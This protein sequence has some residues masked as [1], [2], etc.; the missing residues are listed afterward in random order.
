MTH[1]KAEGQTRKTRIVQNL[2][3]QM[4]IFRVPCTITRRKI[5]NS[6][7]ID[8]CIFLLVCAIE[9]YCCQSNKDSFIIK[10]LINYNNYKN[11]DSVCIAHILQ[12]MLRNLTGFAGNIRKISRGPNYSMHLNDFLQRQDATQLA[13]LKEPCILVDEN[14]RVLGMESKINCHLLKNINDGMLHRAFSIFLFDDKNRLLLQQRSNEK[15]TFPGSW[16]NTCCS[17]PIYNVDELDEKT[18]IKK[19]AKRRLLYEFGIDVVNYDLFHYLTRIH[20]RADNFPH[21]GIFGEHE[22]DYIL[23]LKGNYDI[24]YNKNEIKSYRFVE[25]NE[26][27]EMLKKLKTNPESEEYRLTPWFK[28]ISDSYLF[29]WWSKLDDLASVTNTENISRFC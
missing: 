27:R 13:L 8:F 14:D 1:K 26:F 18:G 10:I 4:P 25:C 29:D 17:H 21:D 20:Y 23:F 6:C 5:L 11:C 2:A 15:I 12:K 3:S 24:N 22:I 9:L 19:A 16:T 7:L 28:F